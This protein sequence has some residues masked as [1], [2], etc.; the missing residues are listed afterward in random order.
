M[1]EEVAAYTFRAPLSVGVDVKNPLAY[2][3]LAPTLALAEELSV[4][5]DWLPLV[6]SP[7]TRP[8]EPGPKPDRGALHHWHRSRYHE[9]ALARSAEACGVKLGDPYR[10]PDSTAAGAALLWVKQRAPDL[11]RPFLL[12][13]FERYWSETLDIEDAA[14]LQGLMIDLAAPVAGFKEYIN[15]P[16]RAEC[17]AL[18]ASLRAAG[19]FS[20]PT[21]W[22]GG[23]LFLGRQ[24]LPM[25]RRLLTAQP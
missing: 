1:S 20:V 22:V 17:E 2:F 19:G 24:H 23:E 7:L 8:A 11:V 9:R 25:I 15:G 10:A 6:A 13:I 14:A 16:G 4:E 12:A 5:I 3:A 21:Y 18:G